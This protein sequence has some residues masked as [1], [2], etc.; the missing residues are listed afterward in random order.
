MKHI[1]VI[2][3]II[4]ATILDVSAQSDVT[5]PN[6]QRQ[7]RTMKE[8]RD[9]DFERRR[10]AM[11]ILSR[12][13]P[14]QAPN[15]QKRLTKAERKKITE[16]KRVHREDKLRY[17]GFLRQSKTG[18]FRVLPDY[19][20]ETRLVI[21]IDGD[22]S[23]FVPGTWAY[24]F[25]RKDYG[26]EDFHD[27]SFKGKNFVVDSLLTQGIL[28]SLG[29]VPIEGLSIGNSALLGYIATFK[30]GYTRISA[31]RQF[32]DISKGIEKNGYRYSNKVPV[33]A[34]TTYLLRVIAYK[35]KDKWSTRLW[36]K[37]ADKSTKEERKFAG[38]KFDKRNDSIFVFRVIRKTKDRIVT[39]LWKRL[40]KTKAPTLIYQRDDKLL[41]FKGENQ[42]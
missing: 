7:P 3:T 34:N 37:N 36:I 1:L 30:P 17:K 20:C 27:L 21:K 5:T 19:G 6:G 25:R 33:I 26:G 42:N 31:A 24:S 41:D 15:K 38:I 4:F 22:C 10:L 29:D 12:P 2:W 32:A 8:I 9:A 11:S 18:I 23:S 13:N 28:V 14:G 16:V 35:Y 40:L 39:I